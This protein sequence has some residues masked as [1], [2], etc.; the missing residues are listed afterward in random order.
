MSQE[1]SI[2]RRMQELEIEKKRYTAEWISEILN[3]AEFFLVYLLICCE[4]GT[5]TCYVLYFSL[6][7]RNVALA[8]N[9]TVYIA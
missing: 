9:T 5:H 7:G 1:S 8:T 2:S 3:R 4:G 6:D